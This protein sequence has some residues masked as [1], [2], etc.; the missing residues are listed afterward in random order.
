MRIL[1]LAALLVSGAALAQ[2]R[3]TPDELT[4]YVEGKTFR[5]ETEDGTY[6]GSEQYLPDNRVIWQFVTG[7]C[8]HG[9]WYEKGK[10]ICYVY[11][12][13]DAEHC[14]LVLRDEAGMIIRALDPGPDADPDYYESGQNNIPLS[15]VGP[16]LGI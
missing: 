14:W 4:D 6:Q 9:L 3:M 10:A 11:E 12:G 7:E 5:F 16:A 13:D 1:T 8:L 2:E 15:C